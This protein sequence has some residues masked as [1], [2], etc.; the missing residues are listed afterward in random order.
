M[1]DEVPLSQQQVPP[2]GLNVLQQQ[3]VTV[4]D[5]QQVFTGV[6][7]GGVDLLL[8]RPLQVQQQL[9]S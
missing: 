8:E 9:C 4:E 5:I 6:K 3:V 1:P 2:H 7:V